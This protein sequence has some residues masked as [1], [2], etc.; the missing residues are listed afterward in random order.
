M[1]FLQPLLLFG[2]P[3]IGLPILI[4]LINQWRHR[5]LPWGAMMF[6]LDAKRMTRGMARLRFWLIM[7]ARML[8]VAALFLAM[9]R[10]LTSGWL[11]VAIGHQAETTLILLDR[12]SSMEQ[13]NLAT[14]RS[15]RSAALTQVADVLRSASRTSRIVLIESTENSV[16][17]LDA[18]EAL[19]RSF[20]TT[21]TATTADLP[22]LLHKALDYTVASQTG[23]TDIW[24]C[25]DLREN[26]WNPSD[27]RWASIRDGFQ[28][29]DGV[30]FYL[31][32]YDEPAHDN[33]A[34]R[35]SNVRQRII[36]DERELIFDV[37][38][39]SEADRPT[40]GSIPCEVII[41]GTRSIMDVEMT[42]NEYVLQ[43]YQVPLAAEATGGWGRVGLPAD[44]NPFDNTAYFVFADP[45]VHHTTIVADDE[46]VAQT[47]RIAATA[48]FDPAVSYT[49]EVLPPAH[50]NEVD[51]GRSSLILWQTEI[52]E[53]RLAEQLTAFV[54]GGR[55]IVFFPP[56]A[57]GAN[58]IFGVAWDNWQ[59]TDE[60]EV[61]PI[62]SWRGDS[63]VWAHSASGEPL[64][65]G[66]LRTY[67]YRKIRGNT[68]Y[69]LARL[70]P[71]D[72]LLYRAAVTGGA[73]Y[74]CT[75]LPLLP[76]SSL[77][78]DGLGFYALIQRAL[79][80]GAATQGNARDVIAGSPAAQRV[81]RWQPA[82]DASR[83]QLPSS[84]WLQP[85]AYESEGEWLALNRPAS[86]DMARILSREEAD[87]LLAGLDVQH[88]NQTLAT[89]GPLT[90]EV[91]RAVLIIM[92]LALIT[93]A[94][95]CMPEPRRGAADTM[96]SRPALVT[97]RD[98]GTA[99]REAT[100][101][102][103][104]EAAIP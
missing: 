50:S 86:E 60:D 45:P 52:P 21:G 40:S 62:A 57:G 96:A 24:I 101:N 103:T 91:W 8:A 20:D 48:P 10:P 72:P 36:G 76:Y 61:I 94:L 26:D 75:T 67:A 81:S 97:R 66:E 53:G 71:G 102:A 42:G 89:A 88:V 84:R 69:P 78:Q 87:A 19:F 25:S 9:A 99:G 28:A 74:F 92:A 46:R 1:S 95:L 77:A 43:G 3:L 39:T 5:T 100:P 22:G 41:N 38:L 49:S 70:D 56:D 33:V 79:S 59:R 34:I 54:E 98:W 4:H 55:S 65:I 14:A 2:L 17:E 30:K 104:G 80:G 63:D 64:G 93:E 29:L 83:Q 51:F 23:R 82:D 68:G 7:A 37:R 18:P 35:V 85:G 73:A 12:S 13:Q 32:S 31:L 6:L 58:E 16:H 90:S 11:G 44:E 47:L 15:K 27:G